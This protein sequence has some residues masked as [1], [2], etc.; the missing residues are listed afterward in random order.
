MELKTITETEK[1]EAIQFFLTNLRGRNDEELAKARKQNFK[2]FWNR[3]QV[4]SSTEYYEERQQLCQEDREKKADSYER[5]KLSEMKKK[6]EEFIREHL[7]R[8]DEYDL[9]R[10][11]IIRDVEL[12]DWDEYIVIAIPFDNMRY[13]VP[14]FWAGVEIYKNRNPKFSQRIKDNVKV[15]SWDA[16]IMSN[17]AFYNTRIK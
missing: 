17:S 6:K 7:I 13:W 2:K 15:F 16:E 1:Q 9:V 10:F 8:K 11:K 14:K 12:S 5:I 3:C 4:A